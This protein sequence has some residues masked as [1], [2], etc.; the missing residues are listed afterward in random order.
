MVTLSLFNILAI[1]MMPAYSKAKAQEKVAK[2][3]ERFRWNYIRQ[4][5]RDLQGVESGHEVPFSDGVRNQ[6]NSLDESLTA[7]IVLR[8][9][10]TLCKTE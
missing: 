6:S 3:K 10:E 7:R 2:L 5:P 1:G 8:G 9:F 4:R